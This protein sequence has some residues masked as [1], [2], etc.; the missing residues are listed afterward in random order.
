MQGVQNTGFTG[1]DGAETP[2]GSPRI[3]TFHRGDS[4][5]FPQVEFF[6]ESIGNG[7]PDHLGIDI[8]HVIAG[9]APIDQ[10]HS[11]IHQRQSFIFG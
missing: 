1:C 6:R 8:D 10:L 4:S 2:A 11:K 3:L 7:V 5:A 9:I